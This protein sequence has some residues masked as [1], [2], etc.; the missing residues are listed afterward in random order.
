[1]QGS[2]LVDIPGDAD[3]RLEWGFDITGAMAMYES[4][5][6]TDYL[7][8][9]ASPPAGITLNVLRAG[10]SDR[11]NARMIGELDAAVSAAAVTAKVRPDRGDEGSSLVGIFTCLR[12]AEHA[13]GLGSSAVQLTGAG[14]EPIWCS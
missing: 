1:M 12:A 4:Y 11:W 8:L 3:G 6:E 5:R 13:R 2:N 9:L 10:A 7:P 14:C